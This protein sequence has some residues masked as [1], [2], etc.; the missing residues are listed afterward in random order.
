MTVV[1][2][3]YP[4]APEA[5]WRSSRDALRAL[6]ASGERP[7][8]LV[9]DSAGGGL[10]LALAQDLAGSNDPP[11]ALVPMA[12]WADVTNPPLQPDVEDDP[13]LSS[14]GLR[15][16]GLLR[17]GDDVPGHPA[18]SPLN[19][20]MA[21]LPPTLVLSGTRDILFPQAVALVAAMKD[22]GVPVEHEIQAGLLHVYPL[23]PV[24]EARHAST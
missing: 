23:L 19:A 17:A 16:C 21:G 13:S 9:G 4:L 11:A 8:V 6:V 15:Q 7:A 3:R 10:A 24:P 12:P 1:V 20:G 18:A 22:A 14:P 2:P 5:T